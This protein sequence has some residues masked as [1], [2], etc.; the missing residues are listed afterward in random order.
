M[1]STTS[2]VDLSYQK[3]PDNR[4][5]DHIPGED[6][7][8]VIGKVFSLVND[9]N[10]LLDD[11]YQR[12]G[13]LSRISMTGMRSVLALGPDLAKTIYLDRDRNF[14][15]KMG[16]N[17]S[18]ANFYEGGLLLR[19]FDEHRFQRRLMQTAF[20]NDSM[21]HYVD[22]MNPTLSEGIEQWRHDSN[23]HFHPS[24]KTSLL[25]VAAKIFIGMDDLNNGDVQRI[26][27]AFLDITERG[28]MAIFKW[29]LPGLAFHAGRNGKRFMEH[30][31]E[32]QIPARRNGD[33]KDMLSHFC[34]EKTEHG[35]YFSNQDI[36]GHTS[37]L[38]FAAH[39]TTTSTLSHLMY[40]LA[41]HPE[42]QE[43]LRDASL[44][45]NKPFLEYSDLDKMEDLER[46]VL[47]ALRMHPSVS[48]MNR[49]TIRD[50]EL[51]GY[52]IPANTMVTISP[53]FTHYM[54]EWWSNPTQFDPDRFS[55]ERAEHKRHSFQYFPFGGGAHKCIGMHFAQMQAKLFMHQMLLKYRFKLADNSPPQWMSV[56]MPKPKNDLPLILEPLH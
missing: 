10:G 5:L 23:F 56:P 11:H 13:A 2:S 55:P 20:K 43:R 21:K 51:E 32:K 29:E 31:L 41:K 48:V 34:R 49:R 3:A 9:L 6:G 26:N 52:H 39:D 46:A 40:Y 47:E 1:A 4:D 38:L 19:D 25:N 28:L 33:G 15:A 17:P 12:F 42:W 18:L 22:V 44:A 45:M 7:W 35:D 54:E 36:V 24:I 37:F 14:S 16:Y 30:Y 50:C 8:P 53:V 27:Q